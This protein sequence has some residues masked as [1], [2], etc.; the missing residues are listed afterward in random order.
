MVLIK[1]RQRYNS[2]NLR[3]GK[4]KKNAIITISLIMIMIA[5]FVCDTSTKEVYDLTKPNEVNQKQLG[6]IIEIKN[7][8]I[9]VGNNL[10]KNDLEKWESQEFKEKL[11]FYGDHGF[12]WYAIDNEKIFKKLK[13]GQ[14]IKIYSDGDG[15]QPYPGYVK[16][17]KIIIYK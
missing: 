13:V 11:I 1:K 17:I 4:V 2:E 6:H 14:K 10:E 8:S 7:N 12:T 3:R 9:L 16:P 15:D 5:T